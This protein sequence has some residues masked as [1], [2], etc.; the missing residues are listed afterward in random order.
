MR[1]VAAWTLGLATT[2]LALVAWQHADDAVLTSLVALHGPSAL[3]ATT[4]RTAVP[5]MVVAWTAL[6]LV[7][8]WMATAMAWHAP[9]GADGTGTTATTTVLHRN[10][11]SVV[12]VPVDATCA[13]WSTTVRVLAHGVA[14]V[15]VVLLLSVLL[16]A[17]HAALTAA[18]R[19]SAVDKDDAPTSRPRP[20]PRPRPR[21]WVTTVA[22]LIGTAVTFRSGV[23]A[24]PVPVPA[25]VWLVLV[26]TWG[27][28][29]S[30]GTLVVGTW[31]AVTSFHASTTCTSTW[32]F[33]TT[34]GTDA[35][36]HGVA[37][38]GTVGT[39]LAVGALADVGRTHYRRDVAQ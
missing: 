24:A 10:G 9:C 18:R 35:C 13:T 25:A 8:T 36:E 39:V 29:W 32:T 23:Y 12:T 21:R 33:T 7:G 5:S 37:V 2:T 17:T 34:D 4:A 16:D 3:V 28:G 1:T 11:R 6:A 26:A 31:F 19:A 38:M 14:A 20:R 22:L 30:W 15:E 27:G